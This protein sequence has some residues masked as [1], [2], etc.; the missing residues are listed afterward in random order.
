MSLRRTAIPGPAHH[1]IATTIAAISPIARAQDIAPITKSSLAFIR[2]TAGIDGSRIYPNYRIRE[3]RA[4]RGH[5][6]ATDWTPN[7]LR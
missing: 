6:L 2:A 3:V 1:R 5:N 4:G 7:L